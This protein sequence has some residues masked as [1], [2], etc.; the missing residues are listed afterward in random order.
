VKRRLLLDVAVRKCA[1]VLELNPHENQVLLVRR[2]AL[3]VLGLGLDHVDRV[4]RL[5][6]EG[7][8]LAGER[9]DEDLHAT[10]EAEHEVKRHLFLDAIVHKRAPVL[11]L[12][13]REDQALLVG[14]LSWILDLTMSMV[15]EDSTSRVMVY[16]V[17]VL[18][19]SA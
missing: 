9:L 6:L 7:D 15:S 17:K 13:P 18:T 12:L 11:K 1:P 5:H 2:D 16:P 10:A 3:L 8:G 19:T 4:G 14:G